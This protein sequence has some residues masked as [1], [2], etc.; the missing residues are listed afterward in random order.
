[1]NRRRQ[2][3]EA[4]AEGL[5]TKAPTLEKNDYPLT[6]VLGRRVENAETKH[7]TRPDLRRTLAVMRLAD[8]MAALNT[9]QSAA[10]AGAAAV[11][12]RNTVDDVFAAADALR[13]DGLEVSVFHARLAMG[14]RLAVE[15]RIVSRFGRRGSADARRG[16]LIATQVVEQSLDLDFDAMVSDLAPIDLLLQRAGRLWRHME[17]SRPLPGPMLAV[18]SPEPVNDA[19]ARWFQDAFP[20]AAW[21][22]KNHA[23]LWLTARQLFAREAWQIPEEMRTLMEAVENGLTS[24]E[25]LPEGLT[26]KLLEA[27]GCAQADRSVADANLLRLDD[28]YAASHGGWDADV[29]VPTRI[30][31]EMTIL[32]LARV[33]GGRMVPWCEDADPFRAWALSEV[34]VRKNRAQ[35]TAIPQAL[36]AAADHARRHWTR[37]DQEKLLVP[38]NEDTPGRWRGAVLDSQGAARPFT[39]T[40]D[41]GLRWR[42]QLVP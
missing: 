5:G 30:G 38:L 7:K 6:T 23:L 17:R 12:I 42:A 40:R 33:E 3:I 35:S 2:L 25:G 39:Y 34:S 19:G 14:D 36:K 1:M 37:Y 28:G 10:A 41:E 4:Y 8:E 18:V 20:R 11:W 31:E 13:A 15:D 26:R 9:L 22:Y 32:R 27:T 24:E 16:V 29:R 21:V